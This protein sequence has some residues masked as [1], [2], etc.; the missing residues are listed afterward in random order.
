MQAI[1]YRPQYL[2]VTLYTRVMPGAF[3]ARGKEI[4]RSLNTLK[5]FISQSNRLGNIPM[6]LKKSED[7]YTELFASVKAS[8]A[9]ELIPEDEEEEGGSVIEDDLSDVI[10]ESPAPV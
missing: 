9:F 10:E 6:I 8:A 7:N 5:S 2:R 1:Q 3:K 4:F